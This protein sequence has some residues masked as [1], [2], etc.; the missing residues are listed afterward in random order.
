[1]S[2]MDATTI[3]TPLGPFTMVAGEEGVMSAGFAVSADDLGRQLRRPLKASGVVERRD[4]G[5]LSAAV[6]RYFDGEL[7]AINDIPLAQVGSPFQQA[8]WAAL[9]RIPAGQTMSYGE[10]AVSIKRGSAR[11][12]GSACARNPVTLLVPCHRVVRSGGELGGYHWGLD[13]KRWLLDHERRSA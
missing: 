12:A 8:A 2:T 11:A 6:E 4:L 9:R 13:R 3:A 1:M 5:V 7:D 10:L